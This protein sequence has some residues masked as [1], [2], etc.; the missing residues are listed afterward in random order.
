MDLGQFIL[1]RHELL[2]TVSALIILV[3]EIFTSEKNKSKLINFTL[4]LFA[5]VTFIGFIPG[6]TG[7]LF[8]GSFQ[9]SQFTVFMH[10]HVALLI[11]G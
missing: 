5:L 3:A 9:S 6:E 10:H 4:V 2:L 11:G 7:N 1:M 8:G